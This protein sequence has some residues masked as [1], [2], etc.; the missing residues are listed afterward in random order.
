MFAISVPL[1]HLLSDPI[2]YPDAGAKLGRR[3]IVEQFVA[4][5]ECR[6]ANLRDNALPAPRQMDRLATA[7]VRRIFSRDPTI[8]FQ[9]MQQRH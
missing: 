8:A 4:E 5:L 1:L 6:R 7:I 3:N 9:A 2:Q